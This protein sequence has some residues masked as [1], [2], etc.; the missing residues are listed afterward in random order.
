M[1]PGALASAVFWGALPQ[2]AKATDEIQVYNA[3]IAAVGQFTI[4]Q[5]LNYV[6][7]GLRIPRFLAGLSPTTASTA[8]R[9]SPM[10]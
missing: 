3:E 10:A 2:A 1:W 4:Q 9:N 8:R 7:G 5:H 6:A